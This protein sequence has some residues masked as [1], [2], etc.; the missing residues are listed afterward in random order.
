MKDSLVYLAGPITGLSYKDCLG[1]REYVTGKFPPNIIGLNPLRG[2]KYLINETNIGGNYDFNPLST[3]QGIDCRDRNDVSRSDLIFVNFLGAKEVSIGTVM[4]VAWADILRKPTI[5]VMEDDNIHN[6]KM[7]RG[8]AGFV[9][10]NLDQAI[11]IAL[12]ILLPDL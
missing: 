12:T 11:Q 9:V 2:K 10:S 1:W 8:A 6:H 4:E 3:P 5:I 7:L